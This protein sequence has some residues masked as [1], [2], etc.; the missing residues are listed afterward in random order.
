MKFSDKA[1][2]N[3]I[4]LRLY[5][6]I[7]AILL[8][9][10]LL[11]FIKGSRTFLY[12]L[13]FSLLCIIP[14]VMDMIIYKKD[15]ESRL[16]C[17]ITSI[18]Y[19]LMYCYAVFTTNSVSTFTYIFPMFIVITLFS[20]ML[21][22]IIFGAAAVIIN[23]ASVVYH[24]IAVGYTKDEIPDVE[25]RVLCTLLTAVYVVIVTLAIKKMNDEKVKKIDEQNSQTEEYVKLLRN[26]SESMISEIGDA[27]GKVSILG[28]SVKSIATAM[29]EVSTGSMDT[30]QSI[31][32]QMQQT[33]E[34]QS[35]IVNVKDTAASIGNNMVD[36]SR[37]V[38][39]GKTH[40]DAL[41][42]QVAKSMDANTHVLSQM[43]ELTDYTRKM[44]T[45]IE[46]ITNIADSTVMLSLNA[47]IE[48]A[49]AGDAG[50]GFAVVASEISALANQTM[51]AT[52]NITELINHIN[53][54]LEDVENAVDVVTK[55]NQANASSTRVVK[56]QFSGILKGT[57]DVEN[58]TR[59]LMNI[60]ANLEAANESIV[61]K[62]QNISAITQE[63]SAHANET[64]DS[65]EENSRIAQETI[66]IVQLL[67]DN[68]E[69][70]KSM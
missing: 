9:A 27:S 21:Y 43:R 39:E 68:A 49:R 63:V 26:L 46:T 4:A 28:D 24:L 18:G 3:K 70:L 12:I 66:D 15:N 60:V 61:E 16:I 34:I 48:A 54:E 31:Q 10:Y 65:C 50:R 36:T 17:Y 14:V 5:T 40:M 22:C 33:E 41:A 1:Y 11:E 53:E 64:H 13:I 8:L 69:K 56:E 38:E 45:I 23:I 7:T 20:E 44:N 58:Q 62:I 52:V 59:E 30:A 55:S 19:G 51:A 47:S 6:A 57:E 42:E 32:E 37:K 25:I 67:S 2:G 35:Y 29:G